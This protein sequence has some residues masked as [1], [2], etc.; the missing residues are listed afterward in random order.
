MRSI[1]VLCLALAAS[2]ALAAPAA[3]QSYPSHGVRVIVPFG[4]GGPAD[5][6]ARAVG[7]QLSD[8]LK[9]PFTIENKPGAGAVIGTTEA[10][11]AAPDGYTLLMMSNTHTANETLVPNKAYNLT[12]DLVPIAPINAADLVIVVNPAVEAKTLQEFIALAKARPKQLN[13][14][15][16][17]VGTPYHLAGESFKALSGTDIVH[18]PHR[19]SG[20]AR[21]NVIGGHVQMMID[22]VTTMAPSI[23]AGQVRALATTGASRSALLPDVPTV[24][25]TGLKDFEATIWLGFMAP[26]GTPQAVIDRLNAEMRKVQARPEVK[27][28]WARQGTVGIDMSPA[29]FGE[30]IKADIAKWARI[31]ETA[32]IKVN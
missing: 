20:E 13:Y 21:T 6:Y 19:G 7:Q 3:A 5:I 26:A 17:G 30:F 18:V 24:A 27:A 12:R 31:I 16:S 11:R 15:S 22:S 9:Q 29:Q 23:A 10:A 1:K 32:N 14:A 2:A 4:A 28:E 25:E 8:A